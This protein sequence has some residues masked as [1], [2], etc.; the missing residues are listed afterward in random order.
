MF[1][2]RSGAAGKQTE[3]HQRPCPRHGEALPPLSALASPFWTYINMVIIVIISDP[4]PVMARP[5]LL[6]QLSPLLSGPTSTW[7]LSSSS[8]TL[9]PSWRGPP[10]SV[11]SRLSFLDLHQHGHYRHHQRPC[12]RH[13]EALPPLSAL[14]SPFWTYI[15]M[16][17]I[18]IISDPAPVMARPSL[19]CQLS[20]LLSGPTSTWSLSS[21][22]ATLPPSWRGPPSSVSSR[23]SFLDLHQHGH[24]RHHQRPCPRHGEALPPLSALASP[25]WTYI[26]MVIIV[27]ISDP[28]PVMA[29]PSL[30]CQLSPLLSG[31]TS[32]WSLSSS[33]A[34]LPPSWRGPPSSVSS[35]LSFL[36]LHQHGHYR[37]HQRPCPVM[38]RPSLLCQLSPLLS[39]PT[40]TWSLSSS[41]A[42]LPPSWRGPPSSVSSRLSFLDLHQHGHYRH[43]QR[44]C[45]R[46]GEALPPL[47]AL[48]SPFWT[49]INMVIIVIISD[50]APVMARPSLLCQ[51]SPLLSG[52]TSTWSLSSSSATLPPS[53]RGPPSS[54]SSRLSFL[55]L[56]QYGHYRHH[57]RPCP[58]HGEA[59]PPLSALASPFWTYINMVII[60]IISDPAPVM[61][62]PSLLCQL[63]PLLSGPTSTWSLSSSS[64]TLP[65]HGEALPPLSAL[66][67][68]FWTYINMVIIVIISDPAPVMARPSLL[69]QLSPLLSG[70]TSTW[71]LSSSSAT[72]PPSWRGPPSSVSSRLSFLDLHQHG[73]YRH[74]HL[75]MQQ[76][77]QDGRGALVQMTMSLHQRQV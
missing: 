29:R 58:R 31:P 20:P 10:S 40:S 25:F 7:S 50:P 59:L 46:H 71:S 5:S 73:H 55:D 66:A 75:Q 49:Y 15:N 47:S 16:V 72:L 60:V 3:Q 4:A 67:S 19:L 70:P 64:A 52:P 14:A 30:L 37:H 33:S 12:P 56:H 27:I 11:S 13:G 41:S 43:H 6:C 51:L 18:V 23:L 45:P 34:T 63:S 74:Q 42:T 1:V 57:Q 62:R 22:S 69:C 36:D 77:R 2:G 35:R 8:A 48:A 38:A 61:A 32:T 24:Y 26:N 9:P 39:G 76:R 65:R 53:W 28:A 44:P 21:S 17:I 68:P 54:V